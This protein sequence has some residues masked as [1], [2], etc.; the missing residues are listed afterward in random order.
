MPNLGIQLIKGCLIQGLL[1]EALTGAPYREVNSKVVTTPK[2][3][4]EDKH[5][6]N[7][8]RRINTVKLN[9]IKLEALLN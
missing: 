8:S 4:V 3:K 1:K 6:V 2:L 7:N 9:I 5:G